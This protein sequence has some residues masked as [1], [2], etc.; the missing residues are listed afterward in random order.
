MID[1]GKRGDADAPLHDVIGDY[2]NLADGDAEGLQM[3]GRAAYLLR[4]PKDA[5]QALTEAER[6]DKGNVETLLVRAWRTTRECLPVTV[7][8]FA[9]LGLRF[10]WY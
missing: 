1:T 5:N 6:S 3:V 2:G 7:M 4:S 8:F 9:Y 10:A